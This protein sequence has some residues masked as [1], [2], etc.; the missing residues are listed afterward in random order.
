MAGVRLNT[1]GMPDAIV[2]GAGHNGLVAVNLLASAAS[3]VLVLEAQPE[4]IIHKVLR[5]RTPR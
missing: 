1:T 4:R 3:Q 2:I 5:I